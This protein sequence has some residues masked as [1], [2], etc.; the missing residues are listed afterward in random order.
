MIEKKIRPITV[1]LFLFPLLSIGIKRL[2][3]LPSRKKIL[4]VFC[5]ADCLLFVVVLVIVVVY[6]SPLKTLTARSSVTP[7]RSGENSHENRH[8]P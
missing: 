5:S 3:S 1:S 6:A 2:S 8:C 7:E 4:D